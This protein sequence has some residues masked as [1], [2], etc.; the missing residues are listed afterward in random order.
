MLVPSMTP[1]CDERW[2]LMDIVGIRKTKLG[3]QVN[4]LLFEHDE[5]HY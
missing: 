5:Q 1:C 4:S 3:M 2:L